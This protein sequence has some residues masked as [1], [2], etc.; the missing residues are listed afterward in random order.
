MGGG[1]GRGRGK[2]VQEYVEDFKNL[3]AFQVIKYLFVNLCLIK[4][5]VEFKLKNI[6]VCESL[7]QMPFTTPHSFFILKYCETVIIFGKY[8]FI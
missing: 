7:P 4:L 1:G 6:V 2:E 8:V 3:R 5:Q